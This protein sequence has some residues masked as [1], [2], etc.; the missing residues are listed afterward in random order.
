MT[1]ETRVE[2]G[3]EGKRLPDE[4]IRALAVCAVCGGYGLTALAIW[5]RAEQCG[6]DPS[7]PAL[8]KREGPPETWCRWC[9]GWCWVIMEAEKEHAHFFPDLKVRRQ[10]DFLLVAD[11]FD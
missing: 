1:V 8:R 7:A 3:W 9:D 2:P 11:P 4:A 10:K 6:R 5:E